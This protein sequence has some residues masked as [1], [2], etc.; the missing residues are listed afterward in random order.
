MLYDFLKKTTSGFSRITNI[1]I[2]VT[3]NVFKSVANG[4]LGVWDATNPTYPIS[5]TYHTGTIRNLFLSVFTWNSFIL[6]GNAFLYSRVVT[7]T[8]SPYIYALVWMSWFFPMWL[9]SEYNNRIY[10]SE[11]MDLLC[12]NK[13]N[14]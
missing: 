6:V 7:Y 3:K 5:L 12:K 9:L 14:K 2:N 8:D 1:V 4:C 10:Q 11:M 13:Y